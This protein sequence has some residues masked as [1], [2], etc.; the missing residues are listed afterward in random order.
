LADPE[1]GIG[2]NLMRIRIGTPDFTGDPWYSYDDVPKGQTDE[3]LE[4]FSI[5]KDRRYILPIIKKARKVNPHL[6]FLASP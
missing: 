3:T 4:H 6:L 2:M 1:T 5:E